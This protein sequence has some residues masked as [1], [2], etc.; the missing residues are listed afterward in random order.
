MCRVTCQQNTSCVRSSIHVQETIVKKVIFTVIAFIALTQTLVARAQE[1]ALPDAPMPMAIRAV[2]PVTR[3][4]ATERPTFFKE[5]VLGPGYT[6]VTGNSKLDKA[7]RLSLFLER[8]PG[9]VFDLGAT[10]SGLTVPAYSYTGPGKYKGMTVSICEAD[11]LLTAFGPCNE[12]G[13]AA[14][15]VVFEDLLSWSSVAIP[16]HFIHRGKVAKITTITINAGVT[17]VHVWL[18][19]RNIRLQENFPPK[20]N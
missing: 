16:Q 10:E 4:A 13:V 2:R 7:E 15:S 17:A 18:G 3:P 12:A 6:M 19:F 8:Y 11:P 20:N 9:A 1:N 5:M 14:S